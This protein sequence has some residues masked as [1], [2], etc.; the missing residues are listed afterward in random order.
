MPQL[1]TEAGKEARQVEVQDA[2]VRR[3]VLELQ[4]SCYFWWHA[5]DPVRISCTDQGSP[6]YV[7]QRGAECGSLMGVRAL[8]ML[9]RLIQADIRY[10]SRGQCILQIFELMPTIFIE[11]FQTIKFRE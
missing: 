4:P 3:L 6:Q 5:V 7:L 9:T 8:S 2:G 1:A 10:L 11:P